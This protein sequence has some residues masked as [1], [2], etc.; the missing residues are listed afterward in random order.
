MSLMHMP[1]NFHKPPEIMSNKKRY[2]VALAV[3]LPLCM[4]GS[5]GW[6]YLWKPPCTQIEITGTEHT[7]PALIYNLVDSTLSPR[8]V[9]DRIQRHPWVRTVHAVCYPTRIMRVEITERFPRLLALTEDGI[10]AYYLDELGYMM[11][12]PASPV[13]DVPLLRGS[14]DPYHALLP[15]NNREVRNLLALMP[16]LPVTEKTVIS[17]C[18]LTDAGLTMNLRLAGA[19][20]ITTVYLG[21]DAWERKLYRLDSFWKQRLQLEADQAVDVIDLRFKGQII[22]RKKAI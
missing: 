6:Y 11:P 9:V 10:P 5:T 4:G 7:N 2:L 22:T 15:V 12:V 3:V 19:D 17:E 21:D 20:Q 16:R 13:F 18:G 1:K 8:L 14:T